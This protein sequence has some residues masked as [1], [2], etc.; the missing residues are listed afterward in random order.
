MTSFWIELPYVKDIFLSMEYNRARF[1]LS[2]L[3]Y[4]TE[5]F[6]LDIRCSKIEKF[7]NLNKKKL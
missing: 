6:S 1:Q 7:R 3:P 5:F 2:D 4:F